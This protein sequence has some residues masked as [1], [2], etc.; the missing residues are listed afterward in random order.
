MTTIVTRSG[1]GSPLTHTE[2]DTNFTNLNT[3]KLE[4]AAIP[5]GTAAAPSIS[6]L[7]DADSGLFSPGANQVAVATNGTGRLFIDA[8]GNIGVGTAS[9]NASSKLHV[10][11]GDVLISKTSG[12]ASLFLT[13]S[14]L[15]QLELPALRRTTI[16]RLT[17][18]FKEETTVLPHPFVLIAQTVLKMQDLMTAG[19]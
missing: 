17:S 8:S 16:L 5:L 3:N 9:P 10:A 7:S 11:D 14:V 19:A 13:L 18:G 6:F 15:V 1:K 4:T 2:V 12:Y